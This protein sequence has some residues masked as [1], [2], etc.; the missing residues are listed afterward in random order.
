MLYWKRQWWNTCPE[1]WSLISHNDPNLI[2]YFW[3]WLF[4]LCG[5]IWISII[6]FYCALLV[7]Y[8]A[9]R[10]L[11]FNRRLAFPRGEHWPPHY[12]LPPI[13]CTMSTRRL[14]EY[15]NSP[16]VEWT[17]RCI[18]RTTYWLLKFACGCSITYPT[19]SIVVSAYSWDPYFVW[20]FTKT[21]IF[22]LLSDVMVSLLVCMVAKSWWKVKN[23]V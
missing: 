23:P 14:S 1:L 20:S 8:T 3:L 11:H 15:L 10:P 4:A 6:F 9:L 5:S 22:L 16:L 2:S 13:P 17:V 12:F 7:S 21:L 18:K 19:I